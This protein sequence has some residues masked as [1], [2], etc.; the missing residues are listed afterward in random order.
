M[1]LAVVLDV[2]PIALLA[3]PTD[4]SQ[5]KV[6]ATATGKHPADELW[7]WLQ[8][9]APFKSSR[10]NFIEFALRSRPE[11]DLDTLGAELQELNRDHEHR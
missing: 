5:T 9:R 2:S 7:A 3:P 8:A 6:E 4:N 1:A 10:Q 11:W